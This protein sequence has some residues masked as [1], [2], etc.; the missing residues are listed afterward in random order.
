MHTRRLYAAA[1]LAA[2]S[3]LA[4]T[5]SA[6][7]L[8]LKRVMLSSGGV[9]YFEYQAEVSGWE[10]ME[11][12]V[13]LDQVDDVLKSAVIFD[14]EGGSGVIELQ[15][16]DSLNEIFRTMP[17]GP[18]AFASPAALYAALQGEEVSVDEPVSAK[19]RIVSVVEETEDTEKG[20]TKVRHRMSI[21]TP[22]GL[23]QFIMEDAHG[24]K[25]TDDVLDA[26]V[27]GALTAISTNRQRELRTLKVTAR[28]DGTRTITVGFVIEA[29]LWKTS[30]RLVAGTDNKA[31]MQGW[32]IIE[33]ASGADWKDVELTLVSGNPVTFRQ[34]LYDKYYVDRT[35][36]PVEVLGRVNPRR[37]DGSTDGDE[38]EWEQNGQGTPIEPAP[39][40]APTTLAPESPAPAMQEGDEITVTAARMPSQPGQVA[41][42][43]TEAATSVIFTLSNSVTAGSGQSLTV[44]ILDR[45]IP[46]ARISFYQP[47]THPTHPL[48]AIRLTNETGTGLPPGITTLFDNASGRTVFAGDAVLSV[49]PI[50]EDRILSFAVDQKVRVDKADTHDAIISGAKI[51]H[52]VLE[53]RIVQRTVNSYT[54]KGAANEDRT[55]IIETPRYNWD[56]KSHDIAKVDATYNYLRLPITVGAGKT[57]KMDVVWEKVEAETRTILDLNANTIGYYASADG[58][59]PEPVRAA[60]A[61]VAELVGGVEA[62]D[63]Q[64]TAATAERDR[65]YEGQERIRANLEAVP[66][67]SDIQ[68]RYLASLAQQEDRLLELEQ[69]IQQLTLEKQ[70]AEKA[71]SDYVMSL[72]I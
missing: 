25:F 43:S 53:T 62:I 60:F 57:E 55:V 72:D 13:R 26:K 22:N 32:A 66:E 19:G 31:R 4:L 68:R 39:A 58:K 36:V 59:L 51:S 37:D 56:L 38:T 46:A 48:S 6:A 50:G 30:Y 34:Q 67:G 61:R 54:V 52:G 27:S 16:R 45:E 29:P 2:V 70:T 12:P 17:I 14:E 11:I 20:G 1:L 64:I 3:S 47:Y 41:A 42:E 63:S 21:M 40:P 28:G 8:E 33:N 69:R 71:L 9:G 65:I 35:Y 7:E 10:T 18:E 24:I 15:G 44:P 49:L 23:V 5:A